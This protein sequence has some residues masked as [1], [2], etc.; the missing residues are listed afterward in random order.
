MKILD[1][2]RYV[3]GIKGIMLWLPNKKLY[4]DSQTSEEQSEKIAPELLRVYSSALSVG[5]HLDYPL[6]YMV[7]EGGREKIIFFP[8]SSDSDGN[9][10][11]VGL[12]AFW[13]YRRVKIEEFLPMLEDH[14]EKIKKIIEK[15]KAFTLEGSLN[16]M[17]QT[18]LGFQSAAFDFHQIEKTPP[19]MEV[20]DD[21]SKYLNV[22]NELV[23]L[24][25]LDYL[26][27]LNASYSDKKS[28]EL[29][30]IVLLMGIMVS[31]LLSSRFNVN[32]KEPMEI[33][34]KF[35]NRDLFYQAINNSQEWITT[36]L[37]SGSHKLELLNIWI[38]ANAQRIRESI[39][40]P[41]E[42][43]GKQKHRI[44]NQLNALNKLLG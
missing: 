8:I 1:D 18:I 2:M 38:Q 27:Y 5:S 29:N 24:G 33:H 41:T 12:I 43:W 32:L 3:I 19:I 7:V 21:F 13:V 40:V 34:L 25:A 44:I 9:Q 22:G 17:S 11:S 16:T 6:E 23:S 30:Q 10:S 28:H 37:R 20:I 14:I 4:I 36:I 26:I 31:N 15:E 39:S 42:T 35:T